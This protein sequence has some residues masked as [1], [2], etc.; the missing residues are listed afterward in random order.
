MRITSLNSLITLV[1]FSC[2]YSFDC[3][4]I[5][6]DDGLNANRHHPPSSQIQT[7]DNNNDLFT[8]FDSNISIHYNFFP[9]ILDEEVE[10]VDET[11]PLEVEDVD[12]DIEALEA[13][14]L[15]N[16][17]KKA[18]V[19]V[20]KVKLL[21]LLGIDKVPDPSKLNIGNKPIPEAIL[22]EYKKLVQKSN[23]NNNKRRLHR[24]DLSSPTITTASTTRHYNEEDTFNTM[25]R[26]NGSVVKRITMLPKKSKF[27]SI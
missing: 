18:F 7:D 22:N 9:S 6:K 16:L 15:K 20:F 11:T 3:T 14:R 1:L 13:E 26:F 27:Y 10:G 4:I 24:R 12:I 2:I 23:E 5:I 8:D 21:E 25:V 17:E 19:D